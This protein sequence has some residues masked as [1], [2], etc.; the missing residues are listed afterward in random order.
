MVVL[1]GLPNLAYLVTFFALARLGYTSLCLSSRLAPNAC[2]KLIEETG[3][4]AVI[5]GKTA[6]MTSLVT[7]TQELLQ[8]TIEEIPMVRQEDLDK[9]VPKEHQFQ[10]Q[11]IDREVEARSAVA[12]LHSSGTTG[13][14]KPIPLTHTRFLINLPPQKGQTE[15]TTFPFF[16]RYGNWVVMHGLMDRK[17]IYMSNPNLPIT[18][19]YCMKVLEC[20]RPDVLHVVPYIMSLLAESEAGVDAMAKCQ[21]VVF[22]GSACPDELGNDL[23]AKGVNVESFWGATEIGSLGTS[24]NR[25][26]GDDSW[27]YIRIL[28][29]IMQNIWMKPVGDNAYECIYLHG[30]PGLAVSNSDDPPQSFHSKD[31]FIKHPKIEAWKH[32]GRIDDRITLIN[33]EKVLPLPIENHIRLDPLVHECAVFGVG[34]AIPGLLVFRTASAKDLSDSD[35]IDAIWPTVQEANAK[36][37]SF[38]QLSKETIVPLPAGVGYPKTDKQSIK[39]AQLYQAFSSEIDAMY[40]RLE[41]TGTGTLQLSIADL[42]KWLINTFCE[43]LNVQLSSVND[44]F[45]AAGLNSLQAIQMR[46]LILKNIDL[47][48]NSKKLSQNVIFDTANVARLAKHLNSLRLNEAIMGQEEEEIKEMQAMI[49]RYSNFERHVPG[50][51]PAPQGHVV[52]LTGATGTLGAHIL[53]QLFHHPEVRSVYCLVRGENPKERVLQALKQRE[54]SIPDPTLLKAMKSDLSKPDLGLSPEMYQELQNQTTTVIHGAWAVN[55]NLGVRSFEEQHIKGVYNLTR[56]SLSVHTPQPAHIFFCSSVAVALGTPAPA[57]VPEGP[58]QNLKYTLPQGYGRS[59]LVGEHI[60]LNAASSAGALTRTIRIGQVVGDSKIGFWNDTEAVPLM[61]RSALTLKALP[62]LNEVRYYKILLVLLPLTDIPSQTESWLPVD[63]LASIILDLAG[64]AAAQ[65]PASDTNTELIYNVLNPNTFSWT[66]SLLPALAH[67]GLSFTTVSFD[68]WLQKL[69][70]YERNGGN[71]EKN[72]AVKLIDYYER[73]FSNN[74]K[75]EGELSFELKTAK[76]HSRALREAPR[77]VEDGY[78]Q[79]F[80]KAWMDRWVG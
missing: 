53:A 13:L 15:F 6:Q 18:P 10:R 44:D 60:L 8:K 67:S 79:K 16:H 76:E 56:F 4:F 1:L 14:P 7:E 27:D 61:I 43:D 78:I 54:L 80:V 25:P 39:R 22:A 29:P 63:T 66:D 40:E 50:S 28:P 31:L 72:P 74:E 73:T 55:F 9:P 34:R 12:I 33:G 30:L 2:A 77:L 62:T 38:S 37:E 46:G 51:A 17:T 65:P 20:I 68:E 35:Y 64:I 41:N 5:P 71:P 45:F 57:T 42:E 24:F 11:H 70:D 52:V 23:I 47:G 75:A 32:I 21:R 59:K 69:R 3:A 49:D 19:D 58:I 48:G 36:A 26:P